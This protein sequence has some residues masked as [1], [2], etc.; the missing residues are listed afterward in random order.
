[1]TKDIWINLPVKDVE[2]SKAFF[3][4]LGFIPNERHSQ[5]GHLVSFFIGQKNLVVNLFKSS[6]FESFTK[7]KIPDPAHTEVLFSLSADT[8]AEVDEW[9]QKVVAAGGVVFSPPGEKDGWMYGCAFTDPDG[10]R[11]NILHM[12]L[13]KLPKK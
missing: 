11:W 5:P 7:N 10:H 4:H 2:R 12:D 9:S 6:V 1:M 13:S 8:P 3:I